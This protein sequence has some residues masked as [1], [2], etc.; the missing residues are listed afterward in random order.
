MSAM[1]LFVVPQFQTIYGSLGGSLPLP[2]RVLLT[3]SNIFKKY[4]YI[5]LIGALRLPLLL[6][7][8]EEDR[9][10]PRAAV[11]TMKLRVPVFGIAVP[12]DRARRGSPRRFVD[13]AAFG[14]ADPAGAGDREPRR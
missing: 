4:W 3:M 11:D 5:V 13:A 7:A 9:R 1:L 2:T 12:E 6:Q 8:L 14:R 10:R